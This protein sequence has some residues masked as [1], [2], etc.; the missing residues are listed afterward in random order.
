VQRGST[1]QA[2]SRP[3]PLQPQC[4][5]SAE[6]TKTL[7]AM[8][9]LVTSALRRSA[10]VTAGRAAGGFEAA[11][12]SVNSHMETETDG[13][14]IARARHGDEIAFD[15]LVRRHHSSVQRTARAL[16]RSAAD[17]DDVAQDAWLQAYLHLAR[18]QGTSSFHTWVHAIVRNRA[19][20]HHRSARR[21]PAHHA[22][23]LHDLPAQAE[24]RS[25]ARS[26][27]ELLLDGERQER[28]ASAIAALPRHLRGLLELWH[29][30][31]YSYDQMAAMAGVSTGTVKSRVWQARRRVTEALSGSS[32]AAGQLRR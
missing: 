32:Q 3:R 31:Q 13:H 8:D 27:E 7:R 22:A 23:P 25:A 2:H 21:R 19:I 17:A 10:I 1:V 18:F 15:Q 12:R 29:T 5:N 28:L 6:M 26:P 11:H 16:L 4:S 30:G 14:L 20:D 9:I 24:L